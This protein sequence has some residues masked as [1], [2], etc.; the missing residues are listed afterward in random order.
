MAVEPATAVAFAGLEKLLSN[1]LI[2][3]NELVVVNCSGHT[4]PVEKH[5]LGEQWHV[6]VHLSDDQ[7]P[8]PREGLLS[9]LEQLD[10]K[11]TTILLVDDNGDDALL[12]RRLLEAK[13]SY[14]VFHADN[15][16]DGLEQARQRLPD[17]IISDLTMP[18]MDGFTLLEE[19]RKDKRTQAIPVIVVSAKD[20]T[21]DERTR[22]KNGTIE[23]LYQKGSLSPRMFVEQV[24]QAVSKPGSKE[25]MDAPPKLNGEK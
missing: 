9:A 20:I 4:V 13:K 3:D 16:A 5:V 11:V 17:L 22:L 2:R 24:V 6:D 21:A 1:K 14:R 8:A 15:G 10:E 7:R 25:L 18:T 19:L 12:L 23:A